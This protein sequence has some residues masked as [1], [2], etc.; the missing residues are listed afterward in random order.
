MILRDCMI[1]IQ[2]RK[3]LH[4]V[5]KIRRYLWG[6]PSGGRIDIYFPLFRMDGELSS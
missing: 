5:G 4:R 6:T 3:E 1:F 2:Y